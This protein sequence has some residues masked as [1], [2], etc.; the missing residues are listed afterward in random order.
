MKKPEVEADLSNGRSASRESC[1]AA[2]RDERSIV[3]FNALAVSRKEGSMAN[4]T[5]KTVESLSPANDIVFGVRER[6]R[7]AFDGAGAEQMAAF[8]RLTKAAKMYRAV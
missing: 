5:L 2:F 1:R 8:A 6:W 7:R 3:R 4:W